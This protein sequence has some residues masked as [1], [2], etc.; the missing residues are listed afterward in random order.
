MSE[1]KEKVRTLP[2]SWL[3][4]EVAYSLSLE[5]D[6]VMVETELNQQTMSNSGLD[7][8]S[9]TAHAKLFAKW[10]NYC[11]QCQGLTLIAPLGSSLQQQE[12]ATGALS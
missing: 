10:R 12:R 5:N 7:S 9:N 8:S 2:S 11:H 6:V 1:R 4:D 3:F